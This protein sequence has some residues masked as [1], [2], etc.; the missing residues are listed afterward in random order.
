MS[1][2]EPRAGDGATLSIWRE[3][4]SL[5]GRRTAALGG[6]S[7]D[8]AE[9][10]AE[11]LRRTAA[12]LAAEGFEAVVGPMDGDT[13]GRHRL[14]VESD[15]RAPFLFEP[16]NPDWH[17]AAFDQAGFE[18]IARYQSAEGP[19]RPRTARALASPAG[20]IL[21]AFNPGRAEA[22][23]LRIHALSLTAFARNFL[24]RPL[25]A[26]AFLEAY[27]PALPMLDPELVLL[28]EDSEGALQGFL[29]AVPDFAEGPKPG[30]VVLKTYASLRRGAGS[31]LV[32]A[33]YERAA[34]KG[35]ERMVHAL[36]HETNLSARHSQRVGGRVF[37]RYALWGRAL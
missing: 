19:V 18:V 30:A 37:R 29:F 14:V 16:Q 1:A 5:D 4:P 22:E 24:Y 20:L 6:F 33:F 8:T 27:A 11:L 12:D 7:C 9:A 17:P 36:M 28:A 10:G 25:P 35:Y 26:E 13:W 15:G 31:V 34:A 3:A 2:P 32:N 23:L 21:R